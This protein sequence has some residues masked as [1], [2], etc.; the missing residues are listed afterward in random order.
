MAWQ[1]M[2][3]QC[4]CIFNQR[5]FDARISK[6]DA[7][8]AV[9]VADN[10]LGSPPAEQLMQLLRPRYWFSAHLHVKY[11]ALYRHKE[12]ANGHAAETAFLSLDKCLPGRG[13]LQVSVCICALTVFS[14]EP[15]LALGAPAL[16]ICCLVLPSETPAQLGMCSH[17]FC[18]SL[19][20]LAHRG[21]LGGCRSYSCQMQRAPRSSA[22]TRNGWPSCGAPTPS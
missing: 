9:Q 2:V 6:P 11:A 18:V 20:Q 7:L 10:S 3:L 13:F 16:E 1:Q 5:P 22:M 8:E 15:I 4:S 21:A 19:R 14:H 17:P 12:P